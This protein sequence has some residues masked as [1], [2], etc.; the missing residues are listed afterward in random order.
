MLQIFF[1]KEAC[2]CL[3][4]TWLQCSQKTKAKVKICFYTACLSLAWRFQYTLKLNKVIHPPHREVN[5]SITQLSSLSF[6]KYR[7]EK[8]ECGLVFIS[9]IGFLA[10]CYWGFII[11]VL[12]GSALICITIKKTYQLFKVINHQSNKKIIEKQVTYL[13][14]LRISSRAHTLI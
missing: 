10:Y 5:G 8:N 14:F 2:F 11:K 12:S 7:Y 1:S 13:L 9:I 3:W 4:I 6:L